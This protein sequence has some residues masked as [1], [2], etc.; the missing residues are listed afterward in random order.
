MIVFCCNVYFYRPPLKLREGN[1]FTGMSVDRGRWVF[2]LPGPFGVSTPGTRSLPRDVP[3]RDTGRVDIPGG[4]GMPASGYPR[5]TGV[6]RV[7]QDR[8]NFVLN[9]FC[10]CKIL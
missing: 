9:F 4:V 10:C 3:G 7:P 1:V 6:I 2:L 5:G 8:R